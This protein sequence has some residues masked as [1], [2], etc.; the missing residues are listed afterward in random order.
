MTAPTTTTMTSR[1]F[2][3]A[4]VLVYAY[5]PRDLL[6]R[7][8]ASDLLADALA[9]DTGILSAQVLA[10]FFNAITRKLPAP[11]SIEE[12]GQAIARFAVMPVVPLDLAL[13]QRAVSLCRRYQISY[14]DAQ[15]VAAAAGAGCARIISEDLNPGQSY[16][17]VVVVNPF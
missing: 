7:Q 15:I 10:E 1:D 3:D 8:R 13:V 6:K 17:G 9:N 2:F 5:D 16:D 12:A 11:L 4:N 14:W